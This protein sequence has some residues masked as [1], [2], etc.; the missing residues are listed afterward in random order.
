[1]QRYKTQINP[2]RDLPPSRVFWL[3]F[4]VICTEKLFYGEKFFQIK[5]FEISNVFKFLCKEF[6]KRKQTHFLGR[7]INNFIQ[8]NKIFSLQKRFTFFGSISYKVS[9]LGNLTKRILINN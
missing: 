7:R 1:M 2:S 8:K 6:L 9:C 5:W 3:L 4:N